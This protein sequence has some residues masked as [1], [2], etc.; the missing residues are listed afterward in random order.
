MVQNARRRGQVRFKDGLRVL[1]V[2]LAVA[3]IGSRLL[4][5]GPS[6]N[7]VGLFLFLIPLQAI[8]VT[9]RWRLS[10]PIQLLIILFLLFE[11]AANIAVALY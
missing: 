8:Y 11:T 9:V 10:I 3:A 6:L 5:Y 1:T 7:P 4:F 2:V